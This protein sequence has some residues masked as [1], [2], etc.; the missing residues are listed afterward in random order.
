M[1]T[2]HGRLSQQAALRLQ[3]GEL[4]LRGFDDDEIVEILN[5]SLSSVKRWRKKVEADG[6]QALARKSGSGRSSELTWNQLQELHTILLAG[7]QAS[8]YWTDRWTSRIVANLI[9]KKWNVDYSHSNVRRILHDLGLSYHKPDVKSTK[10]SQ[11]AVDHW[12]EHT[13]PRIKK[14]LTTMV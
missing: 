13:W 12:R 7:A 14:K 10:Y 3:G 2:N 9:L 5:V 6:I 1:S 11:V 8:G 4:I